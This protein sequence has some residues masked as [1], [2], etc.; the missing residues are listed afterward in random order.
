[1]TAT[2][3]RGR[4]MTQANESQGTAQSQQ[5]FDPSKGD[6]TAHVIRRGSNTEY[7]RQVNF[8]G[9]VDERGRAV[10]VSVITDVDEY[11]LPTEDDQLY[12]RACHHHA[13]GVYFTVRVMPTR[14]GVTYGAIQP[15]HLFAT[16]TERDAHIAA[17][18]ESTRKR[19]ARKFPQDA[20]KP[21]SPEAAREALTAMH[22]A[23]VSGIV[24]RTKMSKP[25]LDFALL[26]GW[27]RPMPNGFRP[28]KQFAITPTGRD[29]AA[30]FAPQIAAQQ[31][32]GAK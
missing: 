14:N 10:G 32:G 24:G 6:R 15:R 16:E 11:R 21:N 27:L 13:P 7:R 3:Y 9:I 8:D 12:G 30:E 20:P 25:A 23:R 17:A 31:V 22:A 26:A 29:N 19:Y 4:K 28:A 5:T 18:V 2:A 1:M